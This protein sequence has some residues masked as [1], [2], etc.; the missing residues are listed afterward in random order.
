[1][2]DSGNEENDG[3]QVYVDEIDDNAYEQQ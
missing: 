2:N 1:M 3:N